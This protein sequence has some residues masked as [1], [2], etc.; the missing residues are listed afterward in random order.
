MFSSSSSDSPSL[1]KPNPQAPSL[2]TPRFIS[3]LPFSLPATVLRICMFIYC[4][5]PRLSNRSISSLKAGLRP[6]NLPWLTRKGLVSIYRM[7]GGSSTY[8]DNM[9]FYN[10]FTLPPGGWDLHPLDQIG[11]D[12]I[13]S[14]LDVSPRRVAWCP[15]LRLLPPLYFLLMIVEQPWAAHAP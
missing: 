12:S 8:R 6:C 4:F 1:V 9:R 5:V 3:S 7:L 15:H 11:D 14:C 2:T 10:A 13:Y